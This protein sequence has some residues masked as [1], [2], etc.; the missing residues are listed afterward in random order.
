[1]YIHMYMYVYIN[2]YIYIYMLHMF[3]VCVCTGLSFLAR[4]A[5]LLGIGA[6]ARGP[7]TCGRGPT[8]ELAWRHERSDWLGVGRVVLRPCRGR[9]YRAPRLRLGALGC[10]A[11]SR[12]WR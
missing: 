11:A 1:M 7:R 3:F 5:E 10:R 4:A 6:H 12:P 9:V 2:K 8:R